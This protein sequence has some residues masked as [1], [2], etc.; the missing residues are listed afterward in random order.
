MTL[1]AFAVERRRLQPA[2]VF[3]QQLSID[4]SCPQAAQGAQQK[5]SRMR[6]LSI[7]RNETQRYR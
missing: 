1:P 2:G 7:G 5:T 6:L 4:I 3:A